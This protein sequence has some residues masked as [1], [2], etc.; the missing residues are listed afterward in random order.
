MLSYSI[1]L[2]QEYNTARLCTEK[3]TLRVTNL[4][5]SFYIKENYSSLFN[6]HN[7]VIIV[8]DYIPSFSVSPLVLRPILLMTSPTTT[9]EM[10]RRVGRGK[11]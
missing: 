3:W 5:T 10:E 4:D 7:D 2:M 9:P 8:S 6:T 11:E 1:E